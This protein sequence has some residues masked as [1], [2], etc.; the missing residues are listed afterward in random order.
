MKS[1]LGAF[2]KIAREAHLA[3]TDGELKPHG[4][5]DTQA[6][7]AGYLAG[8]QAKRLEEI[9]SD[10][11]RM[12]TLKTHGGDRVVVGSLVELE[13]QGL[14]FISPCTGGGVVQVDGAKVTVVSSSSPMGRELLGLGLDESAEVITP[15]GT[16]EVVVKGIA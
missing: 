7:E 16:H 3:A 12:E 9:R 15:S 13:D 11:L 8:A 6:I 1:E 14:Y 10:L 2:E 5:Y 4:K